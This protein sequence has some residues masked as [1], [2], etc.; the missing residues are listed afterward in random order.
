M[1]HIRKPRDGK[2]HRANLWS[3]QLE[4]LGSFMAVVGIVIEQNRAQGRQLHKHTC[5]QRSVLI[6]LFHI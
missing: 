4:C 3:S 6:A 1:V 2:V 5:P